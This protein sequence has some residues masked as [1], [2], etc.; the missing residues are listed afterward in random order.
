M[1]LALES[2][3][4]R[5]ARRRRVA[6]A[7]RRDDAHHPA[8][9]DAGG[10]DPGHRRLHVAGAGARSRRRQ[11]DRRLG[12]RLRAL[13]D[14]HRRARVRGRDSGRRP[15]RDHQ[16]R[17]RLEQA[18][19]LDAAGHRAAPAPLPAEEPRQAAAGHGRRGVR[20]RRGD[21]RRG[22]REH[23]R[24]RFGAEA[25]ARAGLRAAAAIATLVLVAALAAAVGYQRRPE[26]LRAAA[27]V[28][29]RRPGQRR[30]DPRAHDLSRRPPGSPSS[31]G[32]GSGCSPLGEWKPR[33]LPGTEAATRP[34]WSPDGEWI[35]YFRSE[36]AASRCPRPADPW[37]ASATCRRCRRRSVA[38]PGSGAR[39]APSPSACRR[40]RCT[41]RST[42]AAAEVKAGCRRV[43]RS[44][45]A[46]SSCSRTAPYSPR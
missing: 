27:E 2:L 37:C 19:A 18:A 15:R 43:R 1:A 3:D 17:A 31:G 20:S 28:R 8:V 14:A 6:R 39:T 34:F 13:R 46:R 16:D 26:A 29:G 32:R 11:A 35:G 25:P 36:S 40:G 7:R 5:G 4:H 30:R 41:A 24:T 23:G 33:E 45:C 44:T 9:D 42:A 10:H 22:R 12:V 21:H 38:T